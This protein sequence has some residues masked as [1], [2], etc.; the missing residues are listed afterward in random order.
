[1]FCFCLQIHTERLM[2][3]MVKRMWI[4]YEREVPLRIRCK[5]K[6][7][8]LFDEI[9][10]IVNMKRWYEFDSEFKKLFNVLYVKNKMMVLMMGPIIDEIALDLI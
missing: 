2:R 6:D 5:Y 10:N 7:I 8:E 4:L 9:V 1:M 3:K